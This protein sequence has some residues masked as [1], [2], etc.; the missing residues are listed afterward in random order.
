MAPLYWRHDG[1]RGLEFTHQGYHA[2]DETGPGGVG[3]YKGKCIVNQ[4]VLR[5][6]LL[7]T[8]AGHSRLTYRNL[9]PTGA[10]WQYSGLRLAKGPG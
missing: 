6:S 5:G 9:F 2:L 3:E 1:E 4:Y 8:P 7:T 10:R